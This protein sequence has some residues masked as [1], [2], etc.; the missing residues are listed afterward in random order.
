MTVYLAHSDRNQRACFVPRDYLPWKHSAFEAFP[1]F[2]SNEARQRLFVKSPCNDGC[3]L[4]GGCAAA[5]L[6][7][8]G[9]VHWITNKESIQG[10]FESWLAQ[11]HKHPRM[12]HGPT[13]DVAATRERR[14]C[15]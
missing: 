11:Q 2:A 4:D 8:P 14:M 13:K 6:P 12:A 1:G 15:P 5:H 10:L 7:L 9:R 3:G